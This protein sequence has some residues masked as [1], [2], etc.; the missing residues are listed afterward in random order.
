MLLRRILTALALNLAVAPA[1]SAQLDENVQTDKNVLERG[2]Y[3]ARA[4][5]CAACHTE[6]D[7]TPY[8]GGRPIETPFGTVFGT[9]ITPD[10]DYGI[11]NY[12]ADDFYHALTEGELPDGTQLY[13]AMPYPSYHSI[14]REDSDAMYAYLM[15]LKPVHLKAPETELSWPFSMRWTLNFWNVMFAGKDTAE[16]QQQFDQWKRGRYLVDVLGHC[17]A[18]HTPRNVLG[19]AQSDKYLQGEVI[20]GY[21]APSLT[22]EG[23]ARRGWSPEALRTFLREGRSAQGSMSNEMYPVFHH[24]TRYLRDEDLNA[25][26]LYLM[27]E[28]PPEAHVVEVGDEATADSPGR[29]HYLNVCAGCHGADGDG[30]PHVAI[31]LQGNST[32]RLQNPRNLV[33][34]IHDGIEARAFNGFERMQAMPGF[35]NELSD[36]DTAELTN[37]LRQTWGGLETAI[38][39]SKVHE[40]TQGD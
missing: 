40:L 6:E 35:A 21:E 39:A 5:D 18:C 31:G 13:P 22:P 10:K 24:S 28:N 27:G 11:G 29:R 20:A 37:Y 25:M 33:K 23:L 9:N 26:S 17:G 36:Q 12:S 14:P 3:L 34:A 15:S 7:G 16:A 8:A 32:L 1:W 4:A 30:I 38:D 19:A 2:Q